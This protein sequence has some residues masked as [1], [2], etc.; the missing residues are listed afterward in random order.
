[1]GSAGQVFEAVDGK[2]SLAGSVAQ[3]IQHCGQVQV[4]LRGHGQMPLRPSPGPTAGCWLWRTWPPKTGGWLRV[5]GGQLGSWCLRSMAWASRSVLQGGRLLAGC[6]PVNKTSAFCKPI[7]LLHA[8]QMLCQKDGKQ[9]KKNLQTHRA[10]RPW[11]AL[12][13]L[14]FAKVAA[15][16]EATG[17]LVPAWPWPLAR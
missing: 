8:L 1:M 15:Q 2:V 14:N 11:C 7:A 17:S 3:Q 9:V 6:G 12:G 16:F 4:S 10:C 5:S 13:L